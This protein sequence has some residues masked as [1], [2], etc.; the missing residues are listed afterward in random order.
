MIRYVISAV[1]TD[2]GPLTIRTHDGHTDFLY[3]CPKGNWT[4]LQ[5][6]AWEKVDYMDFLLTMVH[7]N[8]EVKNKLRL[9]LRCD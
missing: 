8:R 2:D 3:A 7:I 4:N 9:L 5:F 1:L 6:E